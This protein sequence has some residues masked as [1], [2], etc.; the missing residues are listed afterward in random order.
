MNAEAQRIAIAWA[1]GKEPW[2]RCPKHSQVNGPECQWCS[3]QATWEDCPDYPNDLNAMN[4]AETKLIT[5]ENYF[6]FLRHM[7]IAMGKPQT[8]CWPI[9]ATAAHH[10]EAFLRVLNLWK[11]DPAP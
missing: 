10:A 7:H 4:E 2:W 11:E 1:C 6:D 8:P 5:A 3:A 9:H